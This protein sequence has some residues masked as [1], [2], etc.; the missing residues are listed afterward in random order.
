MKEAAPMMRRLM[1]RPAMQT[2]WKLPSSGLKPAAIST[3]VVFT[4]YKGAG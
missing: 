1:M 2:S 4:G 3:V